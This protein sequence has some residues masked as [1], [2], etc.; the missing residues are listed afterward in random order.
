MFHRTEMMKFNPL[1]A[2]LAVVIGVSVAGFTFADA[3]IAGQLSCNQWNTKGF[4]EAAAATDVARCVEDGAS[5]NAKVGWGRKT[6]LLQAADYS[7]SPAVVKVLLDAGADIEA[8]D[9][10]GYTPLHVA[11]GNAVGKR[12]SVAVVKA[13]LDARANIEARDEDGYT[14]LHKAARGDSL[15]LVK[16]L[17]DAGANVNAQ[18]RI[19]QTSLHAA[20]GKRDSVAVVKALLDARADIEAR[21]KGGYTPLHVA[22]EN[23]MGKRD[24]VVVVKALLDAGA[25]HEARDGDDYTPLYKAVR[26]ESIALVK[27]L[28]D[29]GAD[30]EAR[31]EYG[32]KT[33]LLWAAELSK[34]PAVVKALLDA[35]ANPTVKTPDGY[36]PWDLIQRNDP[37]RKTDVYFLIKK[38]NK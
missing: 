7:K 2:L 9:K 12:D 11:V 16:T 33:P 1:A 18:D 4:F 15:A 26:G 5:V 32:Q 25:R 31:D 6:P 20:V 23:A 29:A 19:G 13:L 35:G 22:A 37:L 36:T 34:S 27:A 21:D 28:L 3:A 17:L 24:S 14:P 30:I 38:A 8:R 10:G